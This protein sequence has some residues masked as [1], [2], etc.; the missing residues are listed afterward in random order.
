MESFVSMESHAGQR[1]LPAKILLVNLS[2]KTLSNYLIILIILF[3]VLIALGAFWESDYNPLQEPVSS[4][5]PSKTSVQL[6]KIIDRVFNQPGIVK[7][8]AES[9]TKGT[10]Q[11]QSLTWTQYEYTVRVEDRTLVLKLISELSEAIDASGGEV[12]QTYNQPKE[13]QTTLVIGVGSFIT[14]QI[15]FD[16]P[17]PVVVESPS[18]PPTPQPEIPE[19]QEEPATQFRAAIV[20]D[21]LGTSTLTAHRLLEL[22]EDFTF[23]VLP[24]LE[25][26]TEVAILLHEHQKEVFLHLPMEPLDYPKEFPGKGAIMANMP[27]EEIRQTIEYN[28]Q[29]VPFVAGVNNH[30]GSR[31][32]ANSGEMHVV[33]QHLQER[34]LF[35]LD[36]R[37]TG[38]S[39]AYSLAQ[40]MELK[41]AKRHIFL[42]NEA[43]LHAVKSQ[44]MKLASLA[45]QG[46]PAIAIGHPKEAT[47]RALA[48]MLPEF[49]RRGIT[50]VRVSQLMH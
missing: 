30:M 17:P 4:E 27:A 41:S 23:S 13:H 45:E 9:Q 31:L 18:L 38:R 6:T 32:T 28:L 49:K 46:Q 39:V 3:G 24:H 22:K 15:V 29:T 33:L 21:D 25:K 47:L 34:G 8:A 2:G 14:H 20:I 19:K 10:V 12:F 7:Y 11:H 40:Q 5:F 36:S 16:W 43:S 1:H 26:S 37:T 35:F 42:D 50:I 48:E 44:L